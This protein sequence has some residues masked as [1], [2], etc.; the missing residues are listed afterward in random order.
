[1][2][3]IEARG[4]NK[5]RGLK[6]RESNRSKSKDRFANVE[7]CHCGKKGHIKKHWG[8]LKKENK[9][10]NG[11]EKK[12]ES[13]DEDYLKIKENLSKCMPEGKWQQVY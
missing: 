4:R 12:N 2:L 5:R 7:Y 8:K 10:N 1:M 3:V 13:S 11:K 9:K 6:N